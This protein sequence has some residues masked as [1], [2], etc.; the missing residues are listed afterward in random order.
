M[1]LGVYDYSSFKRLFYGS[2]Q[3]KRSL[4]IK[5]VIN[6]GIL[7]KIFCLIRQPV[8]IFVSVNKFPN[9]GDG[10]GMPVSVLFYSNS[11]L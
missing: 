8:C 5:L 9:K 10:N 7:L 11:F 2:D 6:T 3:E 1:K 4:N